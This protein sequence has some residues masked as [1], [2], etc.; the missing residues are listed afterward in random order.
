MLVALGVYGGLFAFSFLAATLAPGSS[1]AAL[2]GL[3]LVGGWDPFILVTA[4]SLG[5]IAG[6]VFNWYC[7]RFLVHYKDRSWFPIKERQY[8]KA[9]SWF[10][11]YGQASMLLAWVP[12]IGDP[13]TVIAGTLKMKFMTFFVLVAIG[14]ITR[15]IFVYYA[16][17]WWQS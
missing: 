8:K 13:L 12:I 11:R 2:S 3:L 16:V 15:Y 14:K 4:A 6:S 7:G 17:V 5:N 10:K 1:E 9:V